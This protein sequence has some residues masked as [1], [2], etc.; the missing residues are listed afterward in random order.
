MAEPWQNVVVHAGTPK[1]IAIAAGTLIDFLPPTGTPYI[2][3]GTIA[4]PGSN[5]VPFSGNTVL[6]PPSVLVGPLTL[7]IDVTKPAINPP[8]NCFMVV[9]YRVRANV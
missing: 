5:V 3:G 8:A 9:T 6:S 1:T 4:Y 2:V 7:I